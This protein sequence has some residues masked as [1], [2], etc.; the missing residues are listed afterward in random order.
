[1][2]DDQWLALQQEW[3]KSGNVTECTTS[4]ALGDLKG[5]IEKLCSKAPCDYETAEKI[6][7]LVGILDKVKKTNQ[8]ATGLK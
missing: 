6:K 4:G 7:L 3:W 2:D 5:A 8:L 1:M